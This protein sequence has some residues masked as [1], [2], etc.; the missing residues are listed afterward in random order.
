MDGPAE[1]DASHQ[2]VNHKQ[3]RQ[4]V[5]AEDGPVDTTWDAQIDSFWRWLVRW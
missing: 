1:N 5:F 4:S 3:G 2:T